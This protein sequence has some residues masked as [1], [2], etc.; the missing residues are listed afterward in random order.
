MTSKKPIPSISPKPQIQKKDRSMSFKDLTAKR[1]TKDVKF[2]GETVTIRKL[3]V[4]ETREIQ[5]AST[6]L[7]GKTEEDMA[8]DANEGF[9]VL[10]IIITLGVEGG[11]ELEK[12]D[13]ENLPI[14]ELS[15]LSEAIM[16]FSGMG[17]KKGK[18]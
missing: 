5:E 2:M 12:D 8:E 18:G 3:T 13:F 9:E 11:D 14:D 10:R 15:T 7:S 4:K 1:I 17:D 6:R 16:T